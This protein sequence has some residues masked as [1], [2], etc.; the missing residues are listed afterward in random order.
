MKLNIYFF[1]LCELKR[2]NSNTMC[3][4]TCR[5]STLNLFQLGTVWVIFGE[6]MV[7][8][9]MQIITFCVILMM[10]TV[11]DLVLIEN[12]AQ[13]VYAYLKNPLLQVTKSLFD[14]AFM[15]N[16]TLRILGY[17]GESLGVNSKFC[18]IKR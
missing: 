14:I 12:F 8:V 10:E 3:F 1:D 2:P 16:L 18:P 5:F 13:I 4:K 17:L 6:A 7:T 15:I 11:V 9:M